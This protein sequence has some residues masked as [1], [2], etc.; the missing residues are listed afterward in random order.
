[1]PVCRQGRKA[2]DAVLAHSVA[3]ELPE[4]TRFHHDP[5]RHTVAPCG[6]YGPG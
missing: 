5:A 6:G 2:I 1:L 3:F 4:Q